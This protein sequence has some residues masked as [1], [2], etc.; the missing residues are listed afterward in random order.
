MKKI[1]TLLFCS[2]LFSAATFAQGGHRDWNRGNDNYAYQGRDRDHNFYPNESRGDRDHDTYRVS[3]DRDRI[4]GNYYNQQVR[5][6]P[7]VNLYFT[8]QNYR[9][10]IDQRD[11]VIARITA[12]YDNQV[13][14]VMNDWTMNRWEKRDAINNLQAQKTAEINSIYSQCGNTADYYGQY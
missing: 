5:I 2:T 12:Y 8:Y 11:V 10:G 3:Y 4:G 1:F 7:A 6:H 9:Y 14:Q 13:Q